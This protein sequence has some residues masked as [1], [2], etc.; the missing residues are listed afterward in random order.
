MQHAESP[1]S[2]PGIADLVY[3]FPDHA[4]K[5]Q[6]W[7]KDVHT[8]YTS[9]APTV[10]ELNRERMDV[11]KVVLR[12]ASAI[13]GARRSAARVLVTEVDWK[14]TGTAFLRIERFVDE[15]R[16]AQSSSS[17][18]WPRSSSDSLDVFFGRPARDV[19]QTIFA[20]P[21]DTVIELVTCGPD[22]TLVLRD[23]AVLANLVNEHEAE[24]TALSRQCFWYAVMIVHVLKSLYD[25][26]H[27]VE[28]HDS[29]HVEK[30]SASSISILFFRVDEH[31][32]NKI[33][34]ECLK[35]QND[36]NAQI[37]AAADTASKSKHD[38]AM[39]VPLV[40]QADIKAKNA[41]K[42]AETLRREVEEL[43]A[44]LAAK[45]AEGQKANS[46]T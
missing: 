37:V 5:V 42:E 20:W 4:T 22:C 11:L 46:K 9:T 43:K 7:L 27:V 19:V 15:S 40:Q 17:R 39:F 13:Q 8:C 14:D 36:L 24:Y 16:P 10:G 35:R 30:S 38:L 1:Q 28:T 21:T 31:Q 41:E 25:D 6:R 2:Q 34:E 3:E 33:K 18:W 44:K 32:V 23:L 26:M 12:R 45:E 29:V